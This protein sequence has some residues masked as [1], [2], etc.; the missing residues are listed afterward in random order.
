VSTR[1]YAPFT[2]TDFPEYGRTV[3]GMAWVG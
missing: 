1:F 3:F 2:Q